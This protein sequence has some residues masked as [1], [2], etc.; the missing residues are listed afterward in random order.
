MEFRANVTAYRHTGDV[1]RKVL[2]DG[3]ITSP[4][5]TY[6]LVDFAERTIKPGFLENL[7]A[8]ARSIKIILDELHKDAS[9]AERD[10]LTLY[11][12]SKIDES[13]PANISV[14]GAFIERELDSN[15]L[16]ELTRQTHD[17]IRP[18]YFDE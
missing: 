14:A 6:S 11:L 8:V 12:D 4:G 18:D 17:L 2:Y 1:S 9:V 13:G 15:E 7:P 3:T 16:E 10:D 5:A